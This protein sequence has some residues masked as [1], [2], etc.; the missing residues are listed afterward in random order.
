MQLGSQNLTTFQNESWKLVYFGVKG[1]SHVC[2]CLQTERNVAAG[3][4]RKL[5]WV[6]TLWYPAAQAMLATPGFSLVTSL[7]WCCQF[8][9]AWSFSQSVAKTLRSGSCHSHECWLVLVSGWSEF[10]SELRH[11]CFGERKGMRHVIK[12]CFIYL[13]WDEDD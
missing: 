9:R 6:S 12:T 3:C 11:C 1:Q 13:S 8:F 4:T 10:L 2:V 5:C 7:N